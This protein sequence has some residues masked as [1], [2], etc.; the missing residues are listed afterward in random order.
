MLTTE[1]YTYRHTLARLDALPIST[2]CNAVRR[3]PAL[4]RHRIPRPAQSHRLL[5]DRRRR[6][7]RAARYQARRRSGQDP[8]TPGDT[9]PFGDVRVGASQPGEIPDDGQA[10]PGRR[11]RHEETKETGKSIAKGKRVEDR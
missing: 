1:S 11:D 6:L 8:R 5:W 3:A 2:S 7:R 4:H 9:P 10:A